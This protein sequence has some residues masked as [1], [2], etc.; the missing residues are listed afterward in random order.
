LEPESVLL[1]H[2]EVDKSMVHTPSPC[3]SCWLGHEQCG[4]VV[5]L[6]WLAASRWSS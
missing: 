2:T 6:S 5:A 3:R 1:R 4:R